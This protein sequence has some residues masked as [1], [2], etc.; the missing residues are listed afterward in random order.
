MFFAPSQIQKRNQDWGPEK[1]QQQL[2]QAWSQ[3]LQVVDNWVSI[4]HPT[5]ADGMRQTYETVLA[6]AKPDQSYVVSLQASN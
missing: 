5:G 2:A 3:F 1:F 6:G 4:N